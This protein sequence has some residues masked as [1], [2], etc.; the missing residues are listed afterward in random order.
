VRQRMPWA[1][2]VSPRLEARGGATRSCLAPEGRP[3]AAP[4]CAMAGKQDAAIGH[5]TPAAHRAGLAAELPPQVN[6]LSMNFCIERDRNP[7]F[8]AFWDHT[9]LFPR[10]R[11][12]PLISGAAALRIW[13][14]AASLISGP[15]P[16]AAAARLPGHYFSGP[17]RARFSGMT[18]PA[19]TLRFKVGDRVIANT[20]EGTCAGTVV[21]LN[22][23]EPDWPQDVI[24]PYQVFTIPRSSREPLG[25][26]GNPRSILEVQG[27][28]HRRTGPYCACHTTTK[29]ACVPLLSRCLSFVT[30]PH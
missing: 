28:L 23:R 20:D 7:L 14:S 2:V 19:G 29:R 16:A 4:V 25:P 21:K 1:G 8:S 9:T 5:R 11:L 3:R 27:W 26:V 10:A 12:R 13:A 22:Y 15:V 6:G 18:S 30:R 17:R 24:A